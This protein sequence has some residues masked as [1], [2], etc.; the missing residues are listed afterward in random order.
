MLSIE[1]KLR[2]IKSLRKW[3]LKKFVIAG[4]AFGILVK[5]NIAQP[6]F[7]IM[8]IISILS[9]FLYIF[10]KFGIYFSFGVNAKIM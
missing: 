2:E 3:N 4:L 8:F 5:K 10:G 6:F 9:I 1:S 7:N